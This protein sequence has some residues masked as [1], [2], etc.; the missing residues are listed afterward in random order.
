MK[1]PIGLYFRGMSLDLVY[2][3]KNRRF[4]SQQRSKVSSAIVRG[5]SR[6]RVSD[7]TGAFRSRN[8]I[9]SDLTVLLS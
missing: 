1:K 9:G 7:L 4:D 2:D 6:H 8:T 3:L 5:D